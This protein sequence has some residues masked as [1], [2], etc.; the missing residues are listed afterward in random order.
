MRSPTC[1]PQKE[2]LYQSEMEFYRKR[3]RQASYAGRIRWEEAR[4]LTRRVCRQF[5][6][7]KVALRKA[8]H[9]PSWNQAWVD[10]IEYDDGEIDSAIITLDTKHEPP[11][12]NTV[13][14][15]LAHII[16]DVYFEGADDHGRE[17]VGILSW[18]Y[19]YYKV[20]PADAFAVILKRHGVKRRPLR[21]CSPEALRKGS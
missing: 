21:F 7:P 13:L 3:K 9:N 5:K 2:E 18:L 8:G 16:T 1:D 17:F 20:I 10:F 4:H 11:T 12:V 15:E 6:L 19:D 14:H